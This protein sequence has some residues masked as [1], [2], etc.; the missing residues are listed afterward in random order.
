MANHS[1]V[2]AWRMP[3]T[4]EPYGLPSMGSHRVRHDWSHLAAVAVAAVWTI[5]AGGHHWNFLSNLSS[6]WS[7]SFMPFQSPPQLWKLSLVITDINGHLDFLVMVFLIRFLFLRYLW[8]IST[9]WPHYFMTS[10]F[11]SSKILGQESKCEWTQ[12]GLKLSAFTLFLIFLYSLFYI[13]V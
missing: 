4:G 5:I 9:Y 8:T 1:S 2:L 3:G 7:F 12:C 11:A 6:P 10:F 13:G